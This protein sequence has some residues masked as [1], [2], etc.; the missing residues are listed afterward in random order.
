MRR[1]TFLEISAAA[2][3][4]A[5]QP[6]LASAQTKKVKVGYLHT[7]AVDGQIWLADSMGLWKKDS[8]WNS[9]SSRPG[10]NCSRQ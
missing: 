2:S 6:Q 3:L 9:S 8:I 1:R 7:L 5:L 10:L 4:T